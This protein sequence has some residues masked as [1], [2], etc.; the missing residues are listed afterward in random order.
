VRRMRARS[1]FS[2]GY[3][4]TAAVVILTGH[5]SSSPPFHLQ[6]RTGGTARASL[7]APVVLH[8]R[9]GKASA[10]SDTNPDRHTIWLPD[11]PLHESSFPDSYSG[12]G[13]RSSMLHHDQMRSKGDVKRSHVRRK[14][15]SLFPDG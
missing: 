14:I 8:A 12:I 3:A 7:A 1:A 10:L 4:A 13:S 11:Q 2:G 5:L 6:V 9:N 15:G